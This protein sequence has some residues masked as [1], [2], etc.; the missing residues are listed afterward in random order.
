MK[1]EPIDL[2]FMGARE[3]R[4]TVEGNDRRVRRKEV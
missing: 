2:D 3:R 4:P 1:T